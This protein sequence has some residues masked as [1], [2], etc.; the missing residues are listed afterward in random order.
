MRVAPVA[1]FDQ[2]QQS[3]LQTFPLWVSGRGLYIRFWIWLLGGSV[4]AGIHTDPVSPN[5]ALW[6]A[7]M[8][9]CEA[10]SPI[11]CPLLD[12]GGVEGGPLA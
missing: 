2:Q 8:P 11:F 5:T 10:I 4:G 1:L 9:P 12:V 7:R 6:R 3:L